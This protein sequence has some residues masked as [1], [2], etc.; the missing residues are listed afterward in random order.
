MSVCDA[1]ISVGLRELED[2]IANEIEKALKAAP[3]CGA[4]PCEKKQSGDI[5]ATEQKIGRL[6]SA[7]ANSGDIS[8]AYITREIERLHKV[9]EQL[10]L[11]S[12]KTEMEFEKLDFK[13]LDFEEKKIVAAE[14]INKIL[15]NENEVNIEWKM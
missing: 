10:L 12:H 13:S 15:I 6:V 5:L 9:R 2:Y 8:A 14:F 4:L 11:Q 3:P 1:S 7:L